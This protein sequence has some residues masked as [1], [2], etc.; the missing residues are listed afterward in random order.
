MIIHV[1]LFQTLF[2]PKLSPVITL[3][4]FEFICKK[5]SSTLKK[6]SIF[7][8]MTSGLDFPILSSGLQF[9]PKYKA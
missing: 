3:P 4:S 2:Q 6:H 5:S 7:P 1:T 8:L 9:L